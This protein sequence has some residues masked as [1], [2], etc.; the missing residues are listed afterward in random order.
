M[1]AGRVGV[2]D[3]GSDTGAISVQGPSASAREAGAILGRERILASM[4][5]SASNTNHTLLS[6]TEIFFYANIHSFKQR[7]RCRKETFQWKSG[8]TEECT[9]CPKIRVLI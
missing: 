9:I 5:L 7:Y 3:W 6:N 1:P 8:K 2:G 4:S